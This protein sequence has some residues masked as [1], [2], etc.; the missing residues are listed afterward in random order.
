MNFLSL[1]LIFF[2][3][4]VSSFSI[5]CPNY[6]N[7]SLSVTFDRSVVFSVFSC[8]STNKTDRHDI[9]EML[10]KVALNPLT[11]TLLKYQ[12]IESVYLKTGPNLL[13]IIEL[14]L[15]FE[16]STGCGT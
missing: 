2:Y 11:L 14:K 10:L 3:W 13:N 15:T 8:F 16:V 12:T 7:T 6:K 5:Y 4:T 9:T 1:S